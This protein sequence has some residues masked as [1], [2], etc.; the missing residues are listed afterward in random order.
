MRIYNGRYIIPGLA[1]VVFFFLLPFILRGGKV[2]DKPEPQLPPKETAEKCIEPTA[3]MA[4]S[5]MQLLSAWRN[6]AT[7][8]GRRLYTASDGREWKISL[9]GTC[10][11]CHTDHK[12]FCDTCHQAAGHTIFCWDCHITPEELP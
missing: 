8:E 6:E 4:G 7:R 9:T 5:H 12:A 2:Y 3:Y 1:I 10:M 11:S